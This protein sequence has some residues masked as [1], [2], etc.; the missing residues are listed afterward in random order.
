M[1]KKVV[2]KIF[3]FFGYDLHKKQTDV[4]VRKYN[5]F[6]MSDALYRS[7]K[8]DLQINTVIDIGASNGCWSEICT[9]AYPKAE[10]LLV[11]AQKE[12]EQDLIKYCQTKTKSSYVI[13]AAGDKI[14]T[15]YFDNSDLF[16]GLA[17][18]TKTIDSL[19]EVS[20][21]TIDSEVKNRNLQPPF[22][23]KLDTHGY[24]V[25]ILEGAANT[26]EFTNLLIIESY[27]FQIAENSKLFFELC[28][29]LSQKGFYPTEMV[30]LTLREYDDV[31]WQMDIFF[32]RKNHDLFK[33]KNYK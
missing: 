23:I 31:L 3:S 30:D 1:I 2:K 14:G 22:L 7:S 11:E 27:N 18:N 4:P 8:R 26:L 12:H 13:K 28:E 33:Y 15:I 32:I 25:P 9:V 20:V 19:V 6:T 21:T 17:H 10:Y 24:E 5:N 16:G 29:Y